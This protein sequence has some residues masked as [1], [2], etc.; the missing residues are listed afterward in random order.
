MR[1]FMDE[2]DLKPASPNGTEV[3]L[4]KKKSTPE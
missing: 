3:M 2:V 4:V 1:A